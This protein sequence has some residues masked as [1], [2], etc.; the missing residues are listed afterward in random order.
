[1]T[2][3]CHSGWVATIVR[4]SGPVIPRAPAS[5]HACSKI[6]RSWQLRRRRVRSGSVGRRG[7]DRAWMGCVVLGGFDGETFERAVACRNLPIDH[8]TGGTGPAILVFEAP[9]QGMV[10]MT[11]G[12]GATRHHPLTS[13][14][15]RVMVHRAA[16]STVTSRPASPALPACRDC[17]VAAERLATVTD[18]HHHTSS[19]WAA[20]SL[21]DPGRCCHP[22]AA[23]GPAPLPMRGMPS[24]RRWRSRAAGRGRWACR[25][26]EA[27]FGSVGGCP[28]LGE[29]RATR[30]SGAGRDVRERCAF[31]G[32]TAP[33]A[34]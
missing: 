6:V 32:Q 15:P 22:P 21:E 8:R 14:D 20:S 5:S 19:P 23:R 17:G 7:A 4:R 28:G 30:S 16:P 10:A 13:I 25:A 24:A 1:M 2:P 29:D 11:N 26:S 27:G 34:G 18:N 9:V 33:V 3:G 31:W 12:P